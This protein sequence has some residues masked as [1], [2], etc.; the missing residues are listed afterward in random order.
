MVSVRGIVFVFA[1]VLLLI[2][3]WDEFKEVHVHRRDGSES[4]VG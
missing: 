4:P 2:G 1:A 3:I